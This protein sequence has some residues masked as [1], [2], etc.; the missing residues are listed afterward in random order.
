VGGRGSGG[1]S[2]TQRK[3]EGVGSVAPCRGGERGGGGWRPTVCGRATP[4]ANRQRQVWV[5]V[6]T[7]GSK[8][9]KGGPI[10]VATAGPLAWAAPK[11]TV[12]F[13]N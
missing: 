4:A 9:R 11:R 10:G 13:C 7:R 2:A 8:G 1:G 6:A 12:S 3:E 5:G